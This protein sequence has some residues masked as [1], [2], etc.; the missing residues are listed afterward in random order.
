MYI[1]MYASLHLYLSLFWILRILAV[2]NSSSF[3]TGSRG[4]HLSLPPPHYY[5]Y[6]SSL[7]LFI[8]S[9]YILFTLI[10]FYYSIYW[11][12]LLNFI[13]L[14]F[15]SILILLYSYFINCILLLVFT[16][17][18]SRGYEFMLPINSL[19]LTIGYYSPPVDP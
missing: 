11:I 4:L 14:L 12:Y 19:V 6:L 2:Q 16:T 15:D 9:L 13:V 5:S 1:Y 18:F 7:I 17:T 8:H 3:N 10:I